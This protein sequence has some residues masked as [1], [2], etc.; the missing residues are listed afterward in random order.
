M[1]GAPLEDLLPRVITQ[2]RTGYNPLWIASGLVTGPLFGFLGQ[3]WR[4]DRWW[5]GPALVTAALCVEPV[6]RAATGRLANEPVLWAAEVAVG[7][8]VGVTFASTDP[9]VSTVTALRRPACL[10]SKN[11]G[12]LR[13][14]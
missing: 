10:T 9:P 8:A 14:P 4:I 12:A 2:V 13:R 11:G 7:A 1:E 3:R 5:T 6:A